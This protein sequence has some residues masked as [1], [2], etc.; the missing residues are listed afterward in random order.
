MTFRVERLL[1][2]LLLFPSPHFSEMDAR[3][4]FLVLLLRG[5]SAVQI[6][7]V[8]FNQQLIT[9]FQLNDDF[10]NLCHDGSPPLFLDSAASSSYMEYGWKYKLMCI[11][12]KRD[13]RI[14][15]DKKYCCKQG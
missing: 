4:F 8:S 1:M 6:E 9:P 12:N 11:G 3:L 5:V 2:T 15:E 10:S 7:G 14:L 13:D